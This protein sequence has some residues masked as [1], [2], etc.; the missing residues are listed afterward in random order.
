MFAQITTLQLQPG[1]LDEFIRI[2]QDAI[3]PAAAAQQ[4]FGGITLLTDPLIAKVIAV[5]LWETEAEMPPGEIGYDEEQFASVSS[6]LAAPPAREVYEVSLQVEL[7]AEGTA[8]VR[9]I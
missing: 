8:H 2:F 1:K 6:L 4:G 9:G 5:G 7:T 3:A